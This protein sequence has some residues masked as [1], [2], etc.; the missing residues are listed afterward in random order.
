M[1]GTPGD[2]GSVSPAHSLTHTS[3]SWSE[4]GVP[5][6]I[7]LRVMSSAPDFKE[8]AR[9]PEVTDFWGPE[10]AQ[11]AEREVRITRP[12]LELW[13]AGVPLC[14][15]RPLRLGRAWWGLRSW[16]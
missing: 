15:R 4:P 7:N 14:M 16:T 10:T 3:V 13:P 9:E 11:E 6:T 5:V 12:G 8:A 1:A 2:V